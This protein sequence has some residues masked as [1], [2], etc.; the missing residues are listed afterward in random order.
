VLK[1]K[2]HNID[3]KLKTSFTTINKARLGPFKSMNSK[4]TLDKMQQ[5]HLMNIN[6]DSNIF[7]DGQYDSTKDEHKKEDSLSQ[8]ARDLNQTEERIRQ[9]LYSP[10]SMNKDF[11]QAHPIRNARLRSTKIIKKRE[12]RIIREKRRN[13][14]KIKTM[15]ERSKVIIEKKKKA[16]YNELKLNEWMLIQNELSALSKRQ[17]EMRR[18]NK[19]QKRLK[20]KIKTKDEN[21]DMYKDLS[22][23]I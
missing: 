21:L 19:L 11:F 6:Q 5:P 8:P 23:Q 14:V 18:I 12:Q 10:L 13:R 7:D 20:K 1:R 4:E 2:N 3:I 15:E 17:Q 9:K 16:K 22:F